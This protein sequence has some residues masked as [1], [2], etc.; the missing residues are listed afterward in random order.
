MCGCVHNT[1]FVHI[2]CWKE[3]KNIYSNSAYQQVRPASEMSP[4]PQHQPPYP[5][6]SIRPPS[7]KL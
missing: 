1:A 5:P 2:A 7:S 4:D 6:L 3:E